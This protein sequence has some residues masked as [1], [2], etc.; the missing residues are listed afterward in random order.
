MTIT[1]VAD[2]DHDATR[3]YRRYSDYTVSLLDAGDIRITIKDDGTLLYSPNT[4]DHW[5][6]KTESLAS[7][8]RSTCPKGSSLSLAGAPAGEAPARPQPG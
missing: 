7:V 6:P 1:S 3:N 8:E 5:K 2:P 4:E